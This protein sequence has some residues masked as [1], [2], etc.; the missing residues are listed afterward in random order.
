MT[1]P[2]IVLSLVLALFIAVS[3]LAGAAKERSE[4]PE[5]YKWKP[6]H[7]YS[8]LEEWQKDF[9][10]IKEN[11]DKLAAFKGQFAG[12]D[13][14]N[15]AKSMIEFN[16]LAEQI[17]IK[18]EQVWVYVM[19]NY[20]VDMS[21]S[22]WGGREQQ[23][24]MLA[25]DYGQKLA[26]VNPEILLI[27]QE[28]MHKYIADNPELEPYRKSYDDLYAQQAHVLSEQEEEIIAL[29]YN[30]T[31]VPSDVYSKLT[32]ADMKFGYIV[33]ENGDSVEVTDSGWV[34]WRT[35]KDRRVRED[36][37]KNVWEQYQAFGTTMAAL[38]NGNIMKDIYIT[39]ARKYDDCLQRALDGTFIPVE[40]YEK[41]VETTRK[42]AAPLHK[43][44]EIRKR[45]LGVDHYRH[46]DYYVSISEGDEARYTWEEGVMMVADA[47]KPLGKQFIH[48][49]THGLNPNNGWVD[50]YANKNK[51]GG[52]YSSG[53]YGVHP[54]MLYN[55]D[56][57]KGLSLEDVSTVAHEVGHSMHSYY[58]EKEQAIPNKDYAIFNAEVA[59]T[60][61][62]AIMSAK[63]L[64]EAR[65]EYKKAKKNDKEKARQKLIHILESNIDAIRQTFYRQTMFATWE[66]E[67]HKMGERSEPLTKESL[68]DLYYGLLKEFHGPAA[69]YEDL[70]A[71]S[72]AR[73]P[74]F[75]R[76]FYVYTYATSYAASVAIARDI[77]AEYKGDK[78]KKGC[79][80]KYLKYL[81]SGSSKHP[82][83]LLKN[84]GVDM[85]TPAPVESLIAYFSEM[86]DELDMLTKQN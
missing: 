81:A 45:M 74:H 84:A 53:C 34:T 36:Y 73:I 32:D 22:E 26:W 75:Y 52:A 14:V 48:D 25:V 23:L 85:A 66:W 21:N 40:V 64:E 19:Y 10:F 6:E 16:K 50:I 49:I 11:L 60:V 51:R 67:A 42:N 33:D 44:N 65:K 83:E 78:K 24:R 30:V 28:I 43:Y 4:I 55:F 35:N 12:D 56:Y 58:S 77:M 38:M 29:S 80:E 39:K 5:K 46:W 7:I 62:E 69:E 27:P 72:W 86:V 71:V 59:S 41:L 63:L 31:G 9:N 13:A 1:I 61:N 54:F 70:S 15:P 76:G 18:F 3:A 8:S 57:E 68:S 37:F 17:E 79:T 2:R 47:L 20:H 82:V